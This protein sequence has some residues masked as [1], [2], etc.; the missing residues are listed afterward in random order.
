MATTTGR[1]AEPLSLMRN[2]CDE[3]WIARISEIQANLAICPADIAARSELA[4]LLEQLDRPDAALLHWNVILA[5]NPNN[6]QAREG[7]ARC[8]QRGGRPLRSDR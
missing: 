7:V 6:L 2:P 1:P 5:S 4:T 8:R 3:E